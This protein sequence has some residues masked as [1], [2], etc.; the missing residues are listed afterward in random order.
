M[1]LLIG[2]QN[3]FGP[4]G[5]QDT[6]GCRHSGHSP[7]GHGY[8]PRLTEHQPG[9][10]GGPGAVVLLGGL[11][12]PKIPSLRLGLPAS[13]AET[14]TFK[15]LPVAL[16]SRIYHRSRLAASLWRSVGRYGVLASK[17]GHVSFEQ[18]RHL[19]CQA[20][21]R[22]LRVR[23][24]LARTPRTR[25]KPASVRGGQ[26]AGCGLARGSPALGHSCRA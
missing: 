21:S 16:L 19:L 8:R 1:T 24:A 11:L 13:R 18:A 20:G 3:G 25:N 6:G 9:R 26:S 23:V 10:G 7:R 17:G 5:S 4:W 12:F 22:A 14:A 15:P 2:S